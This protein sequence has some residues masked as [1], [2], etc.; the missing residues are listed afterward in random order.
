MKYK[1]TCPECY[2][3]VFIDSM[4][5]AVKICPKCK[6]SDISRQKIVVDVGE[7][8]TNG[9]EVQELGDSV[10]EDSRVNN[11]SS[12]GD[13]VDDDNLK[14]L[15]LNGSS[16]S[17]SLKYISGIIKN[18][19]SITV[20]SDR[21]PCLVGRD[22]IGKEFLYE[23]IRVSNE[24]FCIIF[25]N[26]KWGIIDKKST[27]GVMVNGLLIKPEK[28]TNLKNGDIIKLGKSVNAI[29]LEVIISAIS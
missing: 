12:W 15:L 16:K 10:E 11:I 24:H 7:E 21:C 29:Q 27:N 22:G 26:G 13:I 5:D 23:D 17:I 1:Q 19:F 3:E 18:D 20:E 8:T 2:S 6:G 25:E 14:V 28:E 4:N 9:N